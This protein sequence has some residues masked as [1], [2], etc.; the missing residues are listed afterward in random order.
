MNKSENT[1]LILYASL[2]VQ[3]YL[4]SCQ[5]IMGKI[6]FL[7]YLIQLMENFNKHNFFLY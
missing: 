7:F 6:V 4:I 3:T 2:I 5:T 1:S